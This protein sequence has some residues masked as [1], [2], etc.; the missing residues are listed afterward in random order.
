MG[1]STI[2]IVFA[3]IE[4]LSHLVEHEWARHFFPHQFTRPHT[5][6]QKE[7]WQWGWQIEPEVKYRPRIEC[8]PRGV[9]KSTNAEAWIASM[10]ARRKRK[11]IAYVSFD[12][13]KASKHFDSIKAFLETP[14]L[15]QAYPHCQPKVATLKNAAERWSR[16]ALITKSDAMVVPLSLQGSSRGWKSP[17][18]ERFDVIILDDIDKKGMTV[19]LI[20]KLLDLLKAEIL[21]AGTDKTLVVMPQNLI[22]RDSI[23][24][25]ILDHRADILSDRDF[26]GPYPL[27]KNYEAE[28]V[29]IEG[30]ATGAK[31]W[32]IT[33][34]EAFDPAI[35]IDYAESLLNLYG[36]ETFDRECQQDVFKVDGEKDFREWSEVHHVITYSEFRRYFEA[37]KVPVWSEASQHPIIPANWNI[38]LGLDWGTTVGHPTAVAPLARPPM[39]APLHDSFFAFTEVILPRF[40]LETGE[41]VPDVSPGRVVKAVREALKEWR[42]ADEQVLLRLMSHEASAALNTFRIDLADEL[43]MFFS[44]WKPKRGSGV[45]QVQELLEI[46]HSKPHPFRDGIM[47]RPRIFFIVPDDQGELIAGEFGKLL[48][49]QPTDYKGFARA[50]FEI[51]L[52]SQ[53]N[54]GANKIKDDY[55]DALLGIA[56]VFVVPAQGLTRQEKREQALPP[57]LRD[58]EQIAEIEDPHKQERIN[59]QRM[60]EFQ[61]LDEREARVR[62]K[63][64]RSRPQVPKIGAIRRR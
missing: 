22:H 3:A 16:D 40:P 44:K 50:R 64:S 58:Q 48:V 41:D 47:G 26:R 25:Q 34:G 1:L 36:R 61:K 10:I 24:S 11:M 45:P 2:P 5:E 17:T 8:E 28:K 37:F 19:A 32:R 18:G 59:L 51:P 4:D 7:F 27:L 31:Q 54:V 35:S 39:N 29:N 53:Y 42:V 14:T 9:G 63:V 57:H 62:A 60:V 52:Y 15:I 43:K 55:V 23:C 46:D 38:G 12:E 49:A 21:A 33:S 56:N 20:A 30:D 13:D 6:Y